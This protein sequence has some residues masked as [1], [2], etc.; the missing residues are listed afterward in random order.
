MLPG[1]VDVYISN[2]HYIMALHHRDRRWTTRVSM[3][4]LAYVFG[5][6]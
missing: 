6:C 1:D 4:R 2:T 3:I 5:A